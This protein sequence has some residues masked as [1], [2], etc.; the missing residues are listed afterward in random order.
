VTWIYGPNPSSTRSL[1]E[2]VEDLGFPV[3]DEPERCVKA[4]GMAYRY[5]QI[6]KN[7]G[8]SRWDRAGSA[9]PPD[10]K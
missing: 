7:G 1:K 4:L 5:T 8:R 9:L 3:F 6:R 2:R 10:G